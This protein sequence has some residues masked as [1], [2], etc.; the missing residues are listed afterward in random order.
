MNTAKASDT[1]HTGEFMPAETALELAQLE[2]MVRAFEAAAAVSR[3]HQFFVWSLSYIHPLLPFDVLVCGAYHRLRRTM[4]FDVFQSVVLPE[5]L[6]AMLNDPRSQLIERL[7]TAWIQNGGRPMRAR[8]HDLEGETAD[9][10][11]A[12]AQDLGLEE[13][14][15]H[16][17]ARPMRAT[18]IETLFLFM[19]RGGQRLSQGDR[20]ASHLELLMPHLHSTWRR[21][22]GVEHTLLGASGG[23]DGL[24]A[25]PEPMTEN[26]AA[27]SLTPRER[28]IL[29]WA[30]EGKSN[31]Q[32]AM[33]LG[34]SPL[35]VKNHVQNIL[36][37]LGASNRA[38]AVALVMAQDQLSRPAG[39]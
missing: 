16:G 23:V 13:V 15:V 32:I 26:E 3:R 21:V 22:Q 35:T 36:R 25:M 24:E 39:L 20:W 5:P 17:V 9:L 14:L 1:L 2:A 8:Q 6:L 10:S 38:H 12:Q 37:K 18:E 33:G 34:I 19:G 27:R 28:Q 11:W 29:L 4:C 30:R 31:P 7:T